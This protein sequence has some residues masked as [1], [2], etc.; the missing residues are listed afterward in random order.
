MGIKFSNNATGTLASS[1]SNT[2]TS[3]TLTAGQGGLFPSLAAGDYFYATIYNSSNQMEIVKVTARTSDTFTVVR[4]QEGTTARAYTAGDR[5]DLR[6]T[7]AA[8]EAIVT[9]ATAA[10]ATAE[11]LA[12]AA[13]PKS[14]GTMTG[15]LNILNEMSINSGVSD[16]ITLKGTDR[17]FRLMQE[18]GGLFIYD[19]ERDDYSFRIESSGQLGG[20]G[21]IRQAITNVQA[22]PYSVSSGSWVPTN[23]FITITPTSVSSRILVMVLGGNNWN[24]NR[25]DL[26]NNQTRI[27]RNGIATPA[28]SNQAIYIYGADMSRGG[29]AD[30]ANSMILLDS[31]NTT[32]AVTYQTYITGEFDYGGAIMVALEIQ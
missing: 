11:A 31:P 2:A 32:S 30:W 21:I 17:Q 22:S 27:Y 26:L 13:L 24:H 29:A 23:H 10:A 18:N 28:F 25:A 3:I 8:L 15:L 9:Q 14:G 19:D 6:A 5:V 16:V 7:A 1:I 12:T 4:G 20:K